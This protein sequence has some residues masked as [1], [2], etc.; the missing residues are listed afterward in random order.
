MTE[1]IKKQRNLA[2]KKREGKLYI[3]YNLLVMKMTINT[4]MIMEYIHKKA[5]KFINCELRD[6][7]FTRINDMHFDNHYEL[8]DS[9]SFNNHYELRDSNSFNY[10]TGWVNFNGVALVGNKSER[11]L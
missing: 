9:N 10:S 1:S 11:V 7:I 5:D 2:V 3:V 4:D 6:Y 8:R